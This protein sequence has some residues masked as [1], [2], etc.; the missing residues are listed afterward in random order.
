MFE[1]FK[2]KRLAAQAKRQQEQARAQAA[3]TQTQWQSQHDTVSAMIALASGTG[4][5]PDG[6]MMHRGE[7]CFGS[8]SNCSLIEERK[9]AGHFVAGNA[10]VSIPVGK[11]GNYPIRYHVGATRGHYVQGTPSATAV[12]TG[13][14]FIT[15]HRIVFLGPTQT[16]ECSFD[17]LVGINQDDQAGVVTISVTN[18]QHPTNIAFGS[19]MAEWVRFH[20]AVAL[21]HYHDTTDQLL[22]QLKQQLAD[23]DSKKPSAT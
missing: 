8:L 10:G 4:F 14:M 7:T 6:L 15:D 20:L 13:T 17:K 9:G 2:A 18:R 11:I 19:Q 16:R 12:A 3:A 21:A 22:D 23:I 1:N 5:A